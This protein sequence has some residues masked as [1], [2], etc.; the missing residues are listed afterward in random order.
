MNEQRSPFFLFLFG[1]LIL[2][3]FILMVVA[4]LPKQTVVFTDE[5]EEEEIADSSF[6]HDYDPI[7]GEESAD[8]VIFF[9]ADFLCESCADIADSLSR[10]SQDYGESVAIV[11]KDFPNITAHPLAPEASIAA[12]CAEKQD[13]FWEYADRLFVN[14]DLITET[15][16]EE[17]FTQIAEDLD[18]GMWRFNRCLSKQQTFDD[19]EASYQDSL[20]ADL[21][22]APTLRIN[23]E[24]FTGIITEQELRTIITSQPLDL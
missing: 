4:I 15:T 20:N 11:W 1:G 18:L 3:I 17:V 10:I 19:L 6:I 2:F 12:R 21:T 24:W 13:A 23:D 8:V 5:Q 16:A 14:Q 22:S 7:Q 9:Y